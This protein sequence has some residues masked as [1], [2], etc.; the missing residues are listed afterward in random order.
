MAA[1]AV[2]ALAPEVQMYLPM[3]N[4]STKAVTGITAHFQLPVTGPSLSNFALTKNGAAVSLSGVTLTNTARANWT[5]GGS[6]LATAVSGK[7]QTRVVVDRVAVVVFVLLLL[8]V[9]RVFV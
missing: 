2:F 7:P 5:L 3:Q 1:V 8:L 4:P 9:R 6:A